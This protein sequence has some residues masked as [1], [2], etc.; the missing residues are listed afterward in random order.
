MNNVRR[1]S[2]TALSGIVGLALLIGLNVLAARQA[3][4]W[5]TTVNKRYSLSAQTIDL[6]RT[7]QTPV[8]AVAFY[9]PE[10]PGKPQAEDLLKLFSQATPTFTYEFVDPDR[11]P[12]RA[13]ELE[14]TQTGSVV[15]MAG[16][17]REKTVTPDEQKLIN[18]YARVTN[19]K[20]AKAYLVEGHGELE[21]AAGQPQQS[22]ATLQKTL[23]DQGVELEP[24]TLARSEA[25]PADADLLLI[26]GPRKDFLEHELSLLKAWFDA[27]GRLFVA[28]S[29]EDK[30]NL[31]GWIRAGLSLERRTGF[32]VDPVSRYVTGDA[33]AP[34]VQDYGQHAI[35]E[36]FNLMTVYPT[37]TGLF[38]LPDA[39]KA[40]PDPLDPMGGAA[41][42]P[43]SF[44][45][46]STAQAWFETDVDALKA[47]KAEFD[48][49]TD[50]P[51]PIWIAAVYEGK[52]P[53]APAQTEAAPAAPEGKDAKPEDQV[54]SAD[55]PDA[56]KAGP[57]P[58]RSSRAVLFGDQDFV[59]DKYV[60]IA[61]NLDFARNCANWLLERESLITLPKPQ[62][63]NIFL[64][65]SMPE[66]MAVMWLP[67]VLLPGIF[68]VLAV[69]VAVRRRRSK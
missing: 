23:A 1:Y 40:M 27:G 65:M 25:V 59:S 39:G 34:L 44:L 5:D 33:M 58:G 41:E 67:L 21:A 15:L 35:A 4:R 19:P 7:S 49:K 8:H 46:R 42:S 18:T 69:V 64:L 26:L 6:L 30:T 14:V 47:G 31:D 9:R 55:T 12:F 52:V 36:D 28:L 3:W 32:V 43:V 56:A 54:K 10:E 38:A 24:L 22:C 45:G 16:D 53:A 57:K 61:G 11:T 20:R 2:L 29:A 37:A 13:K 62:A 51:G 66:R 17:K 63:G 60:N 50:V 68:V 48:A